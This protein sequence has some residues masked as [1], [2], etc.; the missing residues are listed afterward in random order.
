LILYYL[1]RSGVVSVVSTA[2]GSDSF[3][4]LAGHSRNLN[5]RTIMRILFKVKPLASG[6]LAATMLFVS[7]LPVAAQSNDGAFTDL[8][9]VDPTNV[10]PFATFYFLSTFDLYFANSFGAPLPWNP[11]PEC[12][13]YYMGSNALYGS[14]AT[15]TYVVDDTLVVGGNRAMTEDVPDPPSGGGDDPDPGIPT[16]MDAYSYP[17]N[18]LWLSIESASNGIASVTAHGTVP[19]QI[20][21]LLSR[22]RLA[23]TNWLSEGTF[24]GAENQDWTPT[25]ITIGTRTSSLFIWCRSWAD[26]DGDGLP[27]WWE[28]QYGLD[29]NNP[30]TGNTGIP[31]GYKNPMNDGWNNLY[32][33]EHGMNPGQFYTPPPPRNVHARLDSTGTNVILTWESGGGPVSSYGIEGNSTEIGVVGSA[34]F[35]FTDSPGAYSLIFD[36]LSYR[37]RAYFSNGSHSDSQPA[38]PAKAG[39][40]PDMQIVRGPSCR[41]YLAVESPPQ[42]LAFVRL[43]NSWWWPGQD[44]NGAWMDVYATNLNQGL[45]ELPM[46]LLNGDVGYAKC[47]DTNGN[48]GEPIVIFE[49]GILDFSDECPGPF[50]TNFVNAASHLKENLKFLLR[51][52]SVSSPFSYLS[53]TEAQPSLP[54]EDSTDNPQSWYVRRAS[55]TNYEYSGYHTFSPGLNYSIMRPT[56]PLGDNYIWRNYL[57]STDD[58]DSDGRFMTGAWSD[59][60]DEMRWL[61]DGRY[62]YQ[63]SGTELPLP[64]AFTNSDFRWAYFGSA[65]SNLPQLW[66]DAGLNVDANT[67]ISLPSGI[68]NCYGL[69][70]KLGTFHERQ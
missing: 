41:P 31:D 58:L 55:P 28:L 50:T 26:G 36:T 2:V 6:L 27:D 34:T 19:D 22:E 5:P 47:Y 11:C 52:A 29:P 1:A 69:V 7:N 18:Y 40:T 37:I 20:Y 49:F 17:S 4:N 42:S 54:A 62:T 23:D 66:T 9:L 12:A 45:A 38:F 68:R 43:Y 57:F 56:R 8:P 48:F 53:D 32:K 3:M 70:V 44:T 60:I 35:T 51:S 10:P 21:E 16:P 65:S 25:T 13:V 67:N 33:Y 24:L 39:L 30:D 59:G 46:S 15:N 64:L 63:G 14:F 61:F